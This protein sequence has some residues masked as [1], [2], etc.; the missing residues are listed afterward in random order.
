MFYDKC[1]LIDLV[2]QC[3][4]E[5]RSYGSIDSPDNKYGYSEYLAFYELNLRPFRELNE[6][7]RDMIDD[8][9]IITVA[10]PSAAANVFTYMSFLCDLGLINEEPTNVCYP[11]ISLL[12]A[13]RCQTFT[14]ANLDDRLT[15]RAIIGGEDDIKALIQK[16][17]E[18][19]PSDISTLPDNMTLQTYYDLLYTGIVP[20]P[21]SVD[22]LSNPY[23]QYHIEEYEIR[24]ERLLDEGLV[25]TYE[26]GRECIEWLKSRSGIHVEVEV[27]P[28]LNVMCW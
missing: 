17:K 23:L 14:L 18:K 27:D 21:D 1:E 28:S 2:N 19:Y 6:L 5:I 8:N 24:K 22:T 15:R 11:L 13:E 12:F 7:V 16:W 10:E 20:G 26:K 25:S 3:I 4:R 9:E